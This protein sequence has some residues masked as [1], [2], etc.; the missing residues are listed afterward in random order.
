M[1]SLGTC[2]GPKTEKLSLRRDQSSHRMLL[3]E[4]PRASRSICSTLSL[5]SKDV[6]PASR[7]SG[8]NLHDANGGEG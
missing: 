7:R 1:L 8:D 4:A 5:H 2:G 3:Q 6:K